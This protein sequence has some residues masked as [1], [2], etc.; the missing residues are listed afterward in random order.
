MS[1]G[2]IGKAYIH[3]TCTVSVLKRCS[4]SAT[5]NREPLDEGRIHN[6]QPGVVLKNSR[7]HISLQKLASTIVESGGQV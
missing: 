2:K 6:P 1:K 4:S 7:A 5:K 3:L